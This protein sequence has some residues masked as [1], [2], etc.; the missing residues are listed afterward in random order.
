[1]MI[2]GGE[3]LPERCWARLPG[4]REEESGGRSSMMIWDQ[5]CD[6]SLLLGI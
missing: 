3:A 6:S 4:E 5:T 1:M 2:E